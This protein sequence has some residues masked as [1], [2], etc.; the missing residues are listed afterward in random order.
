MAMS[1]LH[2]FARRQL[3]RLVALLT[4]L[5]LLASALGARAAL[6]VVE[7]LPMTAAVLVVGGELY[8][9]VRARR[10]RGV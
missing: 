10:R 7:W 4:V 8:R 6:H 9:A 2:R 5:F 3:W 1:P